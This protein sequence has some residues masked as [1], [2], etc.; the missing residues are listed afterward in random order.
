MYQQVKS[1]WRRKQ[2]FAISRLNHNINPV[3]ENRKQNNCNINLDNSTKSHSF[4]INK[5]FE[6]VLWLKCAITFNRQSNKFLWRYRQSFDG[7]RNRNRRKSLDLHLK[8]D[9]IWCQHCVLSL[10]CLYAY[11]IPV[12]IILVSP[13]TSDSV[14][15][16]TRQI[17]TISI[18]KIAFH[19]SHRG[20][21]IFDKFGVNIT[22]RAKS[23]KIT[24]LPQYKK[25]LPSDFYLPSG[26]ISK[27]E[28]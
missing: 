9:L 6:W 21:N 15:L 26:T 3:P 13:S 10:K 22:F 17:T 28:L 23:S 5:Q 20:A 8:R 18:R 2:L 24:V 7:N 16:N 27:S 12:R 1:E 4:S 11:R 14:I 25:I 19:L